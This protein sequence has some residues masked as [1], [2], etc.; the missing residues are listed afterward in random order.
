MALPRPIRRFLSLG[1]CLSVVLAVS[2]GCSTLHSKPARDYRTVQASPN[3]DTA[4]AEKL[5]AK[6][7]GILGRCE[8]CSGCECVAAVVCEPCLAEKVLQEAL[9]ADVRYGPA[10]NTLGTIYLQQRKLYLAA[11]EF[12]YAAGLMPERPEPHNNLGLVYEEAGRLGQAIAAYE[13]AYGVDPMGAEYIGN[14]ARASLKQGVP[15][16]EVRYLLRELRLYDTRPGWI[17]WAEDLMGTNPDPDDR[18]LTFPEPDEVTDFAVPDIEPEPVTPELI[19]MPAINFPELLGP[20]SGGRK[21]NST[22][23]H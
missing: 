8:A 15:V 10:H 7:L 2:V 17:A 16:E 23:E 12:E 9:I 11:W 14:L 22:P 19:P 13:E 3:R 20:A 1:V 5:H 4:R 6:A 21:A 18:E